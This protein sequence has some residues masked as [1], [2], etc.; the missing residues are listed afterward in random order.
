MMIITIFYTRRWAF[1]LPSVDVATKQYFGPDTPPVS[2]L[3]KTTSLV[4]LNTHFSFN[5]PRPFVPAVVE[6]GGM[7]IKKNFDPLS[8]VYA[9]MNIFRQESSSLVQIL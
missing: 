4:I 3:I 2:E 1:Y 7:Q 6:A 5:F 8:K 9:T